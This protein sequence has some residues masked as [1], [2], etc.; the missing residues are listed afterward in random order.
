MLKTAAVVLFLLAFIVPVITFIFIIDKK[1]KEF[2]TFVFGIVFYIL[3]E[4]CIKLPVL[5]LLGYGDTDSI[6]YMLGLCVGGAFFVEILH[7][8]VIKCFMKKKS[9]SI[10]KPVLFMTGFVCAYVFIIWG[11]DALSIVAVIF[12]DDFKLITANEIWVEIINV[13]TMLP[14][15]FGIMFLCADTIKLKKVSCFALAVL[16]KA[17]TDPDFVF[18]FFED[19]GLGTGTGIFYMAVLCAVVIIFIRKQVFFWKGSVNDG[20]EEE[21]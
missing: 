21:K 4:T 20:I 8:F 13:M 18:Y 2:P 1:R 12:L 19:V 9:F 16:L 3:I 11:I 5:S 14:L 15:Q 10:E 17:L 6:M 7:C